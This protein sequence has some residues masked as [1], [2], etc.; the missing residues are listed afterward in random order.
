MRI[1]DIDEKNEDYEQ[2]SAM[3]LEQ[4][5]TQVEFDSIVIRNEEDGGESQFQ[6]IEHNDIQA[7]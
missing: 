3:E 5:N 4:I 2:R 1:L 6:D 7:G